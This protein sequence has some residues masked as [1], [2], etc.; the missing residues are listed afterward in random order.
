MNTAALIVQ[1]NLTHVHTHTQYSSNNACVVQ[2]FEWMGKAGE[3]AHLQLSFIK[4]T[5]V[6]ATCLCVC[7]MSVDL[8]VVCAYLCA[9]RACML[10]HTI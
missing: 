3:K 6:C 5:K 8:C 10:I 2:P 1:P 7:A 4:Y 9:R